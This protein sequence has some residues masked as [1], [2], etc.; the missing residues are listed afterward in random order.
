MKIFLIGMPG[1]G[2]TTLGR[3]LAEALQLPFIDL[4]KEIE[5]HE[6]QTIAEIFATKGE[7][8][9]RLIESQK[10]KHWAWAATAFVMAT[11][12][13]APC[14]HNGIDVIN[15]SGISIFLDLPIREILNRL[16]NN[17]TRPLLGLSLREKEEKLKDLLIKRQATYERANIRVQSSDV[18]NLVQKITAFRAM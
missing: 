3:Q 15:Q 1:S 11:G 16:K 7:E 8:Y 9:F 6:N 5:Q 14:F 13:G 10:L 12:G 18:T 17:S 2:K 4:D